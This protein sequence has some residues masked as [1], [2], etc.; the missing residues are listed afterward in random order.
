MKNLIAAV[1]LVGWGSAYA[2][3]VTIDFEEFAPAPM[4]S[5]GFG[6]FNVEPGFIMEL[7]DPGVYLWWSTVGFGNESS[8]VQLTPTD[9]ST[10]TFSRQNGGIFNL[11]SFDM[12]FGR[13]NIDED[14]LLRGEH[15]DGSIVDLRI[16]GSSAIIQTWETVLLS[17]Q[18][19]NLASITF[20]DNSF[21]VQLDNIVVNI[22]PIPAAVWL[23]GS[24]L[25]GLGFLRRKK[26]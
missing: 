12:L 11:L 20:M 15:G 26:S 22:V 6:S 2:N 4:G 17:G 23:F 7:G 24:G 9:H 14:L 18:L 8:L 13:P 21:P 25:A 3:I 19:D 1:L 16:F 10:V 5:I